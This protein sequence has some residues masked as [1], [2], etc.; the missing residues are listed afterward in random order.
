[1]T[2]NYS[3]KAGD[4]DV[5]LVVK[6]TT[7]PEELAAYVREGL[8][9]EGTHE[10]SYEDFIARGRESDCDC[11]LL[12]CI[13]VQARAHAKDCQFRVALTCA[14]PIACEEHDYDVCPICDQCSC[15]SAP[16]QVVKS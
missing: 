12:Q 9:P 16:P 5:V 11:K 1:M 3:T 14:I 6:S 15:K 2:T 8:I 10:E 13:C 7:T 4:P